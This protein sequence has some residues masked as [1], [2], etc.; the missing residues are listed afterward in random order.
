MDTL[1]FS[2]APKD[3][4]LGIRASSTANL[5]MDLICIPSTNLSGTEGEDLEISM[6][7]LD[8]G[9]IGV[10]GQALVIASASIYCTVHYALECNA[11][12]KPIAKLQSIENYIIKMILA[13]DAARLLT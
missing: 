2:L 7:I 8:G 12:V 13:Q 10:A 6:R 11:F 1:E 4:K 3:D 5:I 9:S